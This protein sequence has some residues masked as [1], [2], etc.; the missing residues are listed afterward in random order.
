MGIWSELEGDGKIF[1]EWVTT[2]LY[3][4]SKVLNKDPSEVSWNEFQK[5][6]FQTTEFRSKQDKIHYSKVMPAVIKKMGGFAN[7][8][9]AHFK[10]KVEPKS[11]VVKATAKAK[12]A[13]A[14]AVATD[15][16]FFKTVEEIVSKVKPG[17]VDFKLP[18]RDKFLE[19]H[20]HL[21]ISDTHF[22]SDLSPEVGCRKYGPEEE[23]RSFGKIII[24]TAEYK[25]QYR[26]NT[27]LWVNLNGDII[28]GEVHDP[29]NYEY[30]SKQC[31]R[32]INVLQHGLE[33][34]AHEYPEIE[35]NCAIGN[36]DRLAAR[37]GTN[38]AM[39]GKD[40]SW[41]YII[42]F[43]LKKY[44]SKYPNVKF[45]LN[46]LPWITYDSF[47]SHFY[48]T[49][50]DTHIQLPYPS[51]NINV[52]NIQTQINKLNARVNGPRYSVVF[53]GHVH[54][55]MMLYLQNGVILIT[56]P[57]LI[58]TDEYGLSLNVDPDA[59]TGQWL[60]E[61]V[62]GFPVGD[63]RFLRITEADRQNPELDKIIPVDY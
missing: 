59:P 46:R 56:N 41:A 16:L 5:F 53:A 27:K 25:R 60:W 8:K 48:G 23:A 6:V 2:G 52:T 57:P 38:R 12:R 20:Q 30:I 49:H 55:G 61:S 3:D 10:P 14:K 35:V 43:S 22:G 44:F 40:D 13:Q 50:G 9:D 15:D 54:V 37:H 58:P 1:I 39:Q 21:L 18:A 7:I 62:E 42:Y 33:L 11:L 47:G 63:S 29:S 34:L 45:N 28:Q 24:E 4:C 19:R 32:A 31:T 51:S 26:K 36:H 17:S